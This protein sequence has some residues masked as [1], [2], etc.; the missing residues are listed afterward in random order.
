MTYD[1]AAIFRSAW[2]NVKTG[3]GH[4]WTKLTGEAKRRLFAQSLR[5]AWKFAKLAVTRKAK[6]P[7]VAEIKGLLFALDCADFHRTRE[8]TAIAALR[9]KLATAQAMAA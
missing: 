7:R 4:C 5:Q 6:N 8:L 1:R 9:A 2:A 3:Y